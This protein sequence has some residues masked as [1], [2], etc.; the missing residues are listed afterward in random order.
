MKFV[1]ENFFSSWLNG[2]LTL[3]ILFVLWKAV[4]PFVGW[5]FLDAVWRPD[6]NAC[7]EAKGACWGFVAE[8]HR[9]ILF[10]TYPYEEHWRPAVATLILVGLWIFSAIRIF[11]R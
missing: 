8:K 7:R 1:R 2:L 11:W 10:G 6:P 5:A 4:P 3:A 9:F